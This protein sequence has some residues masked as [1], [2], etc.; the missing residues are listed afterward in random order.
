[1]IE[2]KTEVP[3]HYKATRAQLVALRS[4]AGADTPL[5][6]R[7][8]NLIEAIENFDAASDRRIHLARLIDIQLADIR[9]LTA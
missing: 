6:H 4:E 5:G 9:R 2:E 1:M 3:N 8:S 7:Y